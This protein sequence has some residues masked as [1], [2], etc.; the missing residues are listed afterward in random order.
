VLLA[1]PNVSEGRDAEVISR[2]G[3]AFATGAALLDI[4][5]DPD[6][7]RSVFTLAGEPGS[8]ADALLS[9]AA[10]TVDAIDMRAHDGVHPFIGALDVC[11]MVW[12]DPADREAAASEARE[13]AGRI[14]VELGVPVFLYGELAESPRRRERSYFRQGGPVELAR[15]MGT[16]ELRPDRGPSLPHPS[17]GATLVGARPPLAAFN[18]ELDTSDLDVARSIAA[19]LREG[20]GGLPGVRAIGLALSNGRTQISTNVHDPSSVALGTVLSEI[21]RLAARHGAAPVAAELIGLVPE[22][23]LRGYPD[24]IPLVGFDPQKHLIERRVAGAAE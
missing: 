13:V 9:G 10:A 23:A 16:R 2:I 1:V 7:N 12:V 11:P 4:H 21:R 3:A 15:R 20:G 8:L 6:H 14:A 17:A 18:V 19:E 24:E 5:S 22:A